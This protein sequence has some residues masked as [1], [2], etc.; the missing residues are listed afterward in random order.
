MEEY[1]CC[2]PFI[3]CDHPWVQEK[4]KQLTQN[5]EEMREKSMSL[6]YFV[7][8]EIK[9]N[10]YLFTTLAEGL[11]AT[12]TLEKREGFCVQKAVL[13]AALSRSVGIPARFRFADIKNHI[14]PEKLAAIMPTDLFLW[15]GYNELHVDGRWL[16][17]TPSFDMKMCQ[18]NQIIPVEFDGTR[19]AVF[20][21]HTLDGR[22]HI[23]YVKDHGHYQDVPL[24]E[25]LDCY[26]CVEKK[27]GRR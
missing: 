22:L 16:K 15:H 21:S 5:Q 2:T 3:D 13:L 14:V 4:A 20:H 18:E 6:F 19:D 24:E 12:V 25:I 1:L 11:R 7:R 26:R 23:E 17:V 9:Y 27:Y 10:P 8:D